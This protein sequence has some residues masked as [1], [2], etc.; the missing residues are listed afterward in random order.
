MASRITY[1]SARRD[2]TAGDTLHGTF[3]ADPYRALEDPDSAETKAWIAAQQATTSASF[4]EPRMAS[5]RASIRAR[6]EQLQSYERV[7]CPFRRGA[8]SYV[9]RNSGLQNQDV[10]YQLADGAVEGAAAGTCELLAGARPFLDLNALF[11]DGTTSL[12]SQSFSEDGKLFAY[13]LSTGGSDWQTLRVRD[14]ETMADLS[15][16]VPWTKFTGIAW[17]HDNSGFFYCRHPAPAMTGVSGGAGT[18]TSA[19]QHAMGEHAV[20]PRTASHG[21]AFPPS[22]LP[23]TRLPTH[24][25]H[26]QSCFTPWARTRRGT[27]WCTPCPATPC[28]DSAWR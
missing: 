7:G 23:H 28:G 27:C 16:L 18:E 13:G 14:V 2:A 12:G 24:P 17:L 8:K 4:S 21:L 1:P 6:L 10:L 26:P 25:T 19:T 9:F 11:P 15:D 22:P 3:I 5:L 20:A